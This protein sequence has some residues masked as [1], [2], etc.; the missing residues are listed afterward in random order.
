MTVNPRVNPKK[1]RPYDQ[2]PRRRRLRIP[3]DPDTSATAFLVAAALWLGLAGVLG[4]LALGMRIVPF[5]F[6]FPFGVFDLGFEL[7]QRRVDAAFANAT[8]YGWLSNA[9]FAA[10]AFMTPRLTGR[11]L[12]LERL[13]LLAVLAWN[14][15]LLGGIAA[16][17]VFEIGPHAPLTAMHWIFDGGLAA[18]AFIVLLSLAL[19]ALSSMRSGYV[20]LWFAGVA[21]LGLLGMLSLNALIGV[22]DWIFGIEELLQGLAS[23]F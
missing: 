9:F 12:A 4:L 3:D 21:L 15:A 8:V 23:V 5:E 22:A 20:S 1:L 10:I 6:S 7:D 13:M 18:G 2:P 17:Y 19:T 11:R 14:S 16:L